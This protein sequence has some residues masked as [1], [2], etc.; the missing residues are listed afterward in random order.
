MRTALDIQLNCD[1]PRE[2]ARW[3][4]SL[5]LARLYRGG[6]ITVAG[7]CLYKALSSIANSLHKEV[8][9]NVLRREIERMSFKYCMT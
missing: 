9:V 2:G 8:S 3:K 1:L 5:A 6:D 4:A 7:C